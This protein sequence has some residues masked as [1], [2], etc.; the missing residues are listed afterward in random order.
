[1]GM[2]DIV[3]QL[4]FGAGCI[5][6]GFF[7]G[8]AFGWREYRLG[9][10]TIAAP[11]LPRTDR[12][13]AY[14]LIVVA[15]LSVASTSF[16]GMQAARQA[17]CNTEFRRT[18]VTRS[19]ISSENQQHLDEMITEI[20]TVPAEPGPDSRARARQ[21]ILDYQDWAAEAARQRAANPLDDPECGR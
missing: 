5:G 16:A 2:S 11:S 3:L 7:A 18:L 4:V 1:M 19:A 20:A 14:V 15:V 12:Q 6:I 13:Q 17:E 8:L 9:G 10:K 21:A